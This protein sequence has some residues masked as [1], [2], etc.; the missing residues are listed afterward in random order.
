MPAPPQARLGARLI[1]GFA[2]GCAAA[3]VVIVVALASGATPLPAF[4]W[5]RLVVV[6]AAG[7]I[8][9]ALLGIGLGY[10]LPA[11]GALPVANIL[12]LSLAFLGGLWGP[13]H[14]L[15]GLGAF[16]QLLPTSAWGD[17]LNGVSSGAPWQPRPWLMLGLY[18]I[19]FAAFATFAYQR[20]E[21][22]RFN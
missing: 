20:D 22:E 1:A 9:F 18:S 15:H 6:L 19:A 4:Q 14:L 12:Y 13:V 7:S 8:P 5:L 16:T 2:I 3:A 17:L 10:A 21:G 11:R